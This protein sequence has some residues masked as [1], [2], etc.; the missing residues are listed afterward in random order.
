MRGAPPIYTTQTPYPLDRHRRNRMNSGALEQSNSNHDSL[1]KEHIDVRR[2]AH[3]IHISEHTNKH[4]QKKNSGPV[5]V[6]RALQVVRERLHNFSQLCLNVRA[7]ET[8]RQTD[9]QRKEDRQTEW[10]KER[11]RESSMYVK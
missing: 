3:V 6:Q 10:D 11:E 2:N 1:R 9:R 8:D 4:T 5:H 7:Q